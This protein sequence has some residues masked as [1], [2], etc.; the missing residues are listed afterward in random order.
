MEK[1]FLIDAMAMIYRAYFALISRP[2]INSKK[3]NTSAVYGFTNF[4]LKIIE[5]E[6]P[7]YL[8]VCFDTEKP[9][10]RHVEYPLYKAQRQEIPTDMPWQIEK[11]K[12]L[13][14]AFNISLLELDGYE[15]DDL[16]GTIAKRE[17]NEDIK[18]YMVTPDKDFTQLVS[19]NILIYKPAKTFS[20]SR[21]SDVEVMDEHK[22]EDKFKVTPDKITEILGLMGDTSDNIPGVKGV[23]EVTAAELIRKYGSIENLYNSIEE[24]KKPKLK[25]NLIKYKDDAFLARKLVT[26]STDVPLN[27]SLED[28][29]LKTANFEEA[30]K[31]FE[32]L[33]FKSLAKKFQSAKVKKEQDEDIKILIL[34]KKEETEDIKVN[35]PPVFKKLKT[36]KDTKHNYFLIKNEDELRRLVNKIKAEEFISFDTETSGLDPLNCELAGMSFSYSETFGFYVPVFGSLKG[37]GTESLLPQSG[38]D[39]ETVLN[40]VKPILEDNNVKK[41]GQNIKFDYLVMKNH[42]IE[43][44]NIIFDTMV[45]AYILEPGG[46]F[47]MNYLAEKYLSYTPIGIEELIGKGKE[48]I[49]MTEL[50][51]ESVKDYACEDADITLQLF[52]R[53]K[54]E[55]QK[56]NLYKLCSDI[57]IPLIKVLAEMEFTG[58]KTDKKILNYLGGEITKLITNLENKIYNFAGTEFNINSTKQLSEILFVKLKLPTTKKTKTGYSTD[59]SVLEELRLEHPII[60]KLLDYRM[61]TKLK[62][63][64]IDGLLQAINRNTGRIHTSFNQV[65]TTTGRLASNNPNLQNIPIRTDAGKSIRK[66]FVPENDKFLILSADYSQI[67][68]RIMAHISKDENM[69]SAFRRG[70]DIHN[71]TAMRIFNVKSSKDITPNMRRKA[72]EVNFGIM[73]G[74]GAF[75]LA[76]RLEIKNTE[77]KA[78]I[79]KYFNEYPNVKDYMEKTKKFAREN[80]YVQTLMGRRRYLPQ[81]NNQNLNARAEDERAAINMPIQGSAAD[82]IKI[83]MINIYDDFQKKKLESKMILQV[84]DE[85]VFEAKITELDEVKKIIQREMKSAIKLDVPIEIEIGTGGNWYEAH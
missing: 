3:Q 18:V 71:E 44:K 15:A 56:V 21:V 39:I 42:G 80:G 32:E 63:T 4:L 7:S 41:V 13:I 17:S 53:I 16:I 48:Q 70:H 65:A 49:S 78:I 5:D 45:G 20:G 37:T 11:V 64:Y 61:L 19:N 43:I 51:P 81:I 30:Y 58:V 25:E 60:S 29:R 33:E 62:S 69:I 59:V 73:Y 55:L 76:T 6:K 77:A 57:E 28:L 40:L 26:I 47:K 38:I 23:G 34:G 75:G 24:I 22:V 12:E 72:K 14:R 68:L 50:P 82:M 46:E 2:L 79:D 74:I 8:A 54:Y 66:A 83:A 67:E 27:Y 52:H 1:L 10:F 85:L 9:T 36:I 84:H 35:I 31:L